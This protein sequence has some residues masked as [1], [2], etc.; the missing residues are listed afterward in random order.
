MTLVETEFCGLLREKLGYD[1]AD[2]PPLPGGYMARLANGFTLY[3]HANDLQESVAMHRLNDT[4]AKG[5][6]DLK[7]L[8]LPCPR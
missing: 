1:V 4:V 2:M 5:A 8:F 7:R 6:D 3:V